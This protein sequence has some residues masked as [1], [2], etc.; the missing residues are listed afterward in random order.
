[1]DLMLLRTFLA[2]AE[3]GS[4]SAAASRLN[5][6]QSNVTARVRRLEEHF[7]KA[8]FE[9]GRGGARLT[10]FGE[11]LR[12]HAED[13][14]IRFE[15]AERDLLDVAGARAPLKLGAMESAAAARLPP[16]IKALKHAFPLAP[17]SLRTGPT[18]ELLA[19]VW[20]R[21]LDAAFVA[22][23]VDRDR[24]HA[25]A[26]F[27]EVLV[28]ARS[29]SE[30]REGPLLAF[31]TGCTYR[32][33]AESWLRG[34]GRGDTEAIE[35]GTLEGILGCVE[36]GMG[37]AV[38]PESAVQ[39]F[40]GVGALELEPLPP[41]FG[42]VET[43]LAWRIDHRPTEAHLALCHLLKKPGNKKRSQSSVG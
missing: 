42:I 27:R 26:A 36:A 15:A 3:T 35:M 30:R 18:A 21:K 37:F 24:F 12:S 40:R 43:L 16:I 25:A 11:R 32:A 13:L 1:M 29:R 7:G 19:L 6:V 17:I 5:C 33:V 23:P 2:V 9:R 41:A 34:V 8:A 22:G 20:G 28:V 38:A 14:L 31:R 10:G 39:T 4:F